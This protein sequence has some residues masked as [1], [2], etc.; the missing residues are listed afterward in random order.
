MG[1]RFSAAL[2]QV[3]LG[4]SRQ[5]MIEGSITD[6]GR[7]WSVQDQTRFSVVVTCLPEA[8]TPCK[9]PRHQLL[10]LAAVSKPPTTGNLAMLQVGRRGR[11]RGRAAENVEPGEAASGGR[12]RLRC[13]DADGAVG[14]SEEGGESM[15]PRR[16][17]SA[18]SRR[19]PKRHSGI[20]VLRRCNIPASDMDARV[21]DAE[22]RHYFTVSS[23]GMIGEHERELHDGGDDNESSSDV[24]DGE[25]SGGP[26]DTDGAPWGHQV[27]N[28][29]LSHCRT[30][31][32][33]QAQC[34]LS[35]AARL[36]TH[37]LARS[38]TDGR[39]Y[40]LTGMSTLEQPARKSK[41][42]TAVAFIVAS[43]AKLNSSLSQRGAVGQHQGQQLAISDVPPR[44]GNTEN[45]LERVIGWANLS[46]LNLLRYENITLFLD[47]TF[48]CV[49]DKFA[50]CVVV[51]VYDRGTKL[52]I[53]VIFV[54]CAS[55]NYDTY[56]NLLQFDSTAC[57]E[58]LKPKEVVCD[59][60]A[61][62]INATSD[63]FPE[64]SIIGCSFHFKQ[65][66]KR[67]IFKY[68]ICKDQVKVAML[69]GMLD[70][71]TVIEKNRSRSRASHG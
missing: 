15:E 49:P 19:Q 14:R 11:L 43:A 38:V 9:T 42:R 25:G 71:L 60:E 37:L 2:I 8:A 68:R 48:R 50:Q 29:G 23:G 28:S 47:G 67:R 58:A 44:L 64:A 5:L 41:S 33:G 7:D 39:S 3:S 61:A 45:K 63:W 40:T 57:G 12:G 24:G 53:P 59:F 70:M 30:R 4:Y 54:P 36:R 6:H 62:L 1:K 31:D 16:T 66:C 21:W 22:D 56:W 26:S 34:R 51:M 20:P 17:T 35:A 69:P 46:L 52:Y 27:M 65:A 10:D 18:P 13:H 55:R 32:C